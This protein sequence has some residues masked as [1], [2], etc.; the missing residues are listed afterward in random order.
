MPNINLPRELV[1]WNSMNLIE[2]YAIMQ[3]VSYAKSLAK[4]QRGCLALIK[5]E[6]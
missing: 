5:A 1:I 6:M 3:R 2:R 4:R